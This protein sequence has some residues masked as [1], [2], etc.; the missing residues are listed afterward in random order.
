VPEVEKMMRSLRIEL[1][2][3]RDKRRGRQAY[4][5]LVMAWS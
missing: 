1:A 2:E 5:R 3:A 4:A